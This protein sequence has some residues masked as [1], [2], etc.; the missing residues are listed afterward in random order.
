MSFDLSENLFRITPTALYKSI[1][2][3]NMPNIKTLSSEEGKT[4]WIN[5]EPMKPASRISS[6]IRR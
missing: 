4:S 1:A 5:D 6:E 2:L 3:K